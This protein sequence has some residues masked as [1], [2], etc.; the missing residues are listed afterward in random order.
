ML[1][2]TKDETEKVGHKREDVQA[3]HFKMNLR[4][5]KY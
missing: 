1:E 4:T 5:A 3:S 2:G